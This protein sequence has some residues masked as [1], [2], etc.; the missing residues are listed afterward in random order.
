P[1]WNF[2]ILSLN[3]NRVTET[4]KQYWWSRDKV[5]CQATSSASSGLSLD[6]LGGAFIFF[7]IGVGIALIMFVAEKIV[8]KVY[9]VEW[10]KNNADAKQVNTLMM[11]MGPVHRQLARLKFL[12]SAGHGWSAQTYDRPWPWKWHRTRTR[13][14]S[15]EPVKS[16]DVMELEQGAR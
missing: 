9:G 6:T 5:T 4:L 1:L 8:A 7:C 10:A 13:R 16:P 2:S 14:N 11:M 12:D 15:V 3:E